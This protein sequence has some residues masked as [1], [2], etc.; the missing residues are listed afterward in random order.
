MREDG[1]PALL[2]GVLTL[3]LS[4]PSR[5]KRIDLT[6]EGKTRTEW[7]EGMSAASGSSQSPFDC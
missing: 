2:R 1:P 5:I 3:N 4:K 7:P 6:L